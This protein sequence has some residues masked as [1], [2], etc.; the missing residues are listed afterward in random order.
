TVLAVPLFM[1]MG[2]KSDWAAFASTFGLAFILALVLGSHSATDFELFPTRTRQTGLS[3]ANALTA[4]LFA[5]T[6]PYALTCLIDRTGSTPSPG[7]FLALLGIVG[8]IT[9]ISLPET[10]GIDLL[11][12]SDLED[13]VGESSP[14]EKPEA[15]ETQSRAPSPTSP[16]DDH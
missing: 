14:V 4:A 1:L 7:F 15:Q 8:I 5:G 16:G 12:S 3:V 2:V 9:V 11:T 10:R 6:A 13:P